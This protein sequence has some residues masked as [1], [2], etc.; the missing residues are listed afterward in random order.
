MTFTSQRQLVEELLTC[1]LLF[2]IHLSKVDESK[3][4]VDTVQ[5]NLV[6][7]QQISRAFNRTRSEP[8]RL[9]PYIRSFGSLCFWTQSGKVESGVVFSGC[10]MC[11]VLRRSCCFMVYPLDRLHNGLVLPVQRRIFKS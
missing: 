8:R 4:A 2:D 7:E 10:E 6:S 5:M 1:C 3:K 11:N 9:Q